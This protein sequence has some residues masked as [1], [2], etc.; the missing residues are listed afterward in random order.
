MTRAYDGSRRKQ[1]ASPA[2]QRAQVGN[3]GSPVLGYSPVETKWQ[4]TVSGR[5]VRPL[6]VE[7]G[8]GLVRVTPMPEVEMELQHRRWVNEE[9]LGYRGGGLC[10]YSE[11]VPPSRLSPSQSPSGQEQKKRIGSGSDGG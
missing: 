8:A 7:T 2:V 11:A 3:N 10:W 1:M 5:L 4:R 6:V 9:G